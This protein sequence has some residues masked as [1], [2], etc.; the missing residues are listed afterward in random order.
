MSRRCGDL[1]GTGE[2]H[3]GPVGQNRV[4]TPRGRPVRAAAGGLLLGL[5]VLLFGPATPAAAHAYL[6]GSDPV[7]GEIRQVAP[8]EVV[9]TFSEPVRPVPD[10]V[11]VVGPDGDRVEA[12]APDVDGVRLTIPLGDGADARGT[13]LVSYRV[14]SVDG[15]P[16]GGSL[17]YSVGAPSATPPAPTV[18]EG[19]DAGLRAGMS[20]TRYVGYAGLIL[21][22][23]PAVMLAL[24]W[25][26]R[27]NR[28]PVARLL[29]IGLGLVG[30]SA[31]AALWLQAP[32]TTGTALAEVTTA[33][34]RD[35]LSSTYGQAHLVRLGVLVAVAVMLR[36]LTSGDAGRTDLLLL[37]VLAVVGFSTWP[38]AGHAIGSPLPAVSLV[39]TVV[40]LAAA[41]FW[42]GGLV[43]LGGFLLRR[44]NE[45]ELGAI[46]PVWSGWA[47]TAVVSLLVAGLMLAVIEVGTPEALLSTSY[48][49]LLLAKLG[50]VAVVVAVAAYSRRLV[51]QRLATT[52]TTAMRVAVAVEAL[53]LAIVVGVSA[54]LVQTTP[55]RT[56]AAGAQAVTSGDFA[57]TLAGELFS[58]QV[59]ID[60]A[61]QGSNTVHLYAFTPDGQPLAVEEWQVTAALPEAGIEPLAVSL[62]PIA[63]NHAFGDVSLPV[64]GDWEFRFTLRISE[65]DQATVAAVVPVR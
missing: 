44:A 28:R 17:T 49:R 57:A 19:D 2:R 1:T 39:V 35:V 21:L 59:L 60:P 45:R 15:H 43:V 47:A 24:L 65:V 53:V 7:G 38:A 5:M 58:V 6:V 13:Y 4:M 8:A 14:I 23:G 29:W 18:A 62:L 40:H 32:Y 33:D 9:L 27:L 42:V 25:P 11:M 54:V 56:E 63:D 37:G 31:L 3:R 36:P 10:R 51:R 26:Q 34:L 52:R 16:V 46:L 30:A 50:L 22:V 55:A 20:V 64:A 41:A 61:A 48:G 12:G